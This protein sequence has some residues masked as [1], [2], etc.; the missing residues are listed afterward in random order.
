M[1]PETAGEIIVRALEQR[2][3]RV[4]VGSDAK[5]LSLVERALPVSYW[6]VMERL[7]ARS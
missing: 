2:R 4:I 6:T 1:P 7:M 5:F 3:A